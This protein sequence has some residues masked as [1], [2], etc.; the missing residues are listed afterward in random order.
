VYRGA[1]YVVDLVPKTRI[2]VV[3]DDK[4][5][6]AI[7]DAIVTSAGTGKIGDGKVWS[8]PVESLVRIRSGERGTDAL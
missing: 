8:A 7:I 4:D 1:E 3:V 5:E 6:D 2:D